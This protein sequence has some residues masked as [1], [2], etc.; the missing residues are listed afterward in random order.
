M[1]LEYTL[2]KIDGLSPDLQ[3]LYI[4]KDGKFLLDVSGIPS[5]ATGDNIPLSRLNEE[6]EKRKSSET[7][8]KEIADSLI[9]A[10]PENMRDVIPELPPGQKI[11]W[12]QSAQKK[13]LFNPNGNQDANSGPDSKR[14]GNSKSGLDTSTLPARAKIAIGYKK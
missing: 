9:E 7:Q 12:I 8:L 4:Q 13:G 2:D 5:P 1:A 6:V 14:P 3:R 11:K 10:V